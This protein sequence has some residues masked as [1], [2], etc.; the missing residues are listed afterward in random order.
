MDIQ[1]RK[2]TQAEADALRKQ[3]QDSTKRAVGVMQP[4]ASEE[5]RQGH[6][7]YVAEFQANGGAF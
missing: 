4:F 5:A 2:L 3:Y 6:L 1:V 7:K